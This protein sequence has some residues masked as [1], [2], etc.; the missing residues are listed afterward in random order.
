MSDYKF[1]D[2]ITVLPVEMVG[3]CDDTRKAIIEAAKWLDE[4]PDFTPKFTRVCN[5]VLAD[6][7][8]TVAMTKEVFKRACLPGNDDIC[9]PFPNAGGDFTSYALAV[10]SIVHYGGF[11]KY[12]NNGLLRS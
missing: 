12:I 2:N 1:P 7:D 10:A 11:D 5:V 6:N 9:L 3:Q 8:E 4:H